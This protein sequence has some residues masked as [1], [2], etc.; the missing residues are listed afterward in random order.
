M[1]KVSVTSTHGLRQEIEAGKH[2]LV[3]DEP[4]ALGGTDTGPTPY[5]LLLSALGACVSITIRL[6]ADRKGWDVDEIRVDLEHDRVRAEQCSDSRTAEGHVDRIQKRI[7]LTGDLTEEQL[8]RLLVVSRRC[9]V[10]QTLQ[11]EVH[12]VDSIELEATPTRP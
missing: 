6:Y 12:I 5:Q 7:T 3:A 8:E 9:P 1:N 2:R 11:R 4:G 10:N